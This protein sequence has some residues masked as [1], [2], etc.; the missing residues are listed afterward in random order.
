MSDDKKFPTEVIDLPSKGW[1]Y[2]PKSPLASGQIELKY[3]SAREEDILTST[4]LIQ[5]GL[6]ID[7]LLQSLI[8][9]KDIEYNDLLIGDKNAILIASRIL[10]YGKSYD[11]T[12]VCTVCGQKG[13]FTFDLTALEEKELSKPEELGVNSFQFELPM[14]GRVLTFKFLT[15]GDEESISNVLEGLQKTEEDKDIDR[16]LTTRLKHIITAVDGDS[17]QSTVWSFI[18]DELLGRDSRAFRTYYQEVTPDID[19]FVDH[20][21]PNSRCE[22]ER[23][24]AVPIGID[25][26]WP[27]TS[28]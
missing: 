24:V 21:C 28:V 4:N 5:K 14:S 19:L 8:V 10:G 6:V 17:K 20:K 27:D 22:N 26:F 1:Y 25:F 11:S 15:Q 9:D 2:D 12:V 23:R 13:K 3:L 18:D 16:T 7:K